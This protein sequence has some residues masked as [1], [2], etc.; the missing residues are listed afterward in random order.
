MN[1]VNQQIATLLQTGQDRNSTLSQ[2]LAL[3]LSHFNSETGTIHR[4][5][6][7]KQ[8]LHLEAHIGVPPPVLEHVRLIPVGKGIAGQTVVRDGPVT[9]CNLQTDTSGVARPD[10]RKTGVGGVLC[11]PLRNGPVIVGTLGIGTVR[12]YEYSPAETQSLEEIGRLL[13]LGLK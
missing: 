5:D 4:L 12:E 13:G 1:E 2:I 3:V 6:R 10:A 9:M 7:E 11:V 8:L